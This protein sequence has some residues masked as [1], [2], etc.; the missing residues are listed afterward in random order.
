MYAAD[1]SPPQWPFP[2][3]K[4]YDDTA[5][6][7]IM[8]SSCHHMYQWGTQMTTNKHYGCAGNY[9]PT[10]PTQNG[11][12]GPKRISPS[13]I[14]PGSSSQPTNLLIN[15]IASTTPSILAAAPSTIGSSPVHEYSG[16]PLQQRVQVH[17]SPA[18]GG[19][20]SSTPQSSRYDSSLGL[21]TKKFVGLLRGSTGNSLDLNKAAVELGVQKRRI[22]DIT[23]VLEGIGRK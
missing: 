3:R 18:S 13:E 9:D 11:Y 6:L 14:T 20:S 23:N 4:Q 7:S 10:A 22:Y 15:D 19:T 16:T 5:E 17:G 12:A 1:D 21:L 2:R 8:K